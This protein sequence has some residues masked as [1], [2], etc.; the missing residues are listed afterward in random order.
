MPS[1]KVFECACPVCHEATRVES[2]SFGGICYT[3]RADEPG[4][5]YPASACRGR[6]TLGEI[7]KS[8]GLSVYPHEDPNRIVDDILSEGGNR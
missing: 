1:V 8:L 2:E 4:S 6:H 5:C 3:Y 7:R